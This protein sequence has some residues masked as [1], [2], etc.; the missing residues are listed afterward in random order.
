MFIKTL[1]LTSLGQKGLIVTNT[2]AYHGV[3]LITAGKSVYGKCPRTEFNLR[4]TK[5]NEVKC[6]IRLKKNF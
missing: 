1:C 3:A 4:A 2:I 6:K 5:I